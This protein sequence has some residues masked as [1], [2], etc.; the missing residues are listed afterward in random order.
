MLTIIVWIV[1]TL[2]LLG[3]GLQILRVVSI[4]ESVK[5]IIRILLIAAAVIYVIL[6][7]VRLVSLIGLPT[8]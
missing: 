3:A 4:D 5:A 6:M 2:I 7:L 1:I 8:V